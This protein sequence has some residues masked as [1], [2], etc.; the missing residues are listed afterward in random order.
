MAPST[1]ATT[2][3]AAR[4]SRAGAIPS[5][6]GG[7][8]VGFEACEGCIEHFSARDDHDIDACSYLEAPEQ[9]T[10]ETLCTVAFDGGSEF[11]RRRHPQSGCLGTVGQHEHCHELPMD[12]RPFVIGTL[13]F[14]SASNPLSKPQG[15]RHW[16][17]PF[18]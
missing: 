3:L 1:R 8:I 15:L 10:C 9:L 11:S 5:V 2:G 14:R 12:A 17:L 7:V 16:I 6:E 18:V 13:E 4:A